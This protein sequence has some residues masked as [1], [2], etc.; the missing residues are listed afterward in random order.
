MDEHQP[1]WKVGGWNPWRE[2]I[3]IRVFTVW[4]TW[5]NSLCNR[6]SHCFNSVP[7]NPRCENFMQTW[8]HWIH[9]HPPPVQKDFLASISTL[10]LMNVCVVACDKHTPQLYSSATRKWIEEHW[11]TPW[12]KK[13]PDLTHWS[14][15]CVYI[16]SFGSLPRYTYLRHVRTTTP[17][18]VLL[19]K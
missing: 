17:Y 13:A 19:N 8:Q 4:G 11:G 1:A 6:N 5:N 15:R 7:S 3:E 9:R 10:S 14:K 18:Y 2:R 16:K 12:N